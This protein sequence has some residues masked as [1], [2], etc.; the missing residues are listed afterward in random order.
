[1]SGPNGVFVDETGR[2]F[3]ADT[4]N[5]VIR[6]VNTDG[7]ITSI[8][9]IP[10]SS[11]YSGDNGPALSAELNFPRGVAV[12][13][14]GTVFI[15]DR[16]NQRIRKVT[17]GNI[18]TMAGI[19][20]AGYTGDGGLAVNARLNVPFGVFVDQTG[21]V[22]I[23][24]TNNFVERMVNTDGI[25]TTIAGSNFSSPHG[26]F[27]DPTGRLF[28]ADSG[29]NNIRM[30]DTNG[31]ST[32]IAGKSDTSAGYTGDG[33]PAVLAQLNSPYGVSVDQTGRVFIADRLNNA[34]R[35]INTDGII[36]TV[37]GTGSPGYTGDGGP[38]SSAQLNNPRGVSVD[39]TG[40]VFIADKENNVIR[41]FQI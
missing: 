22:F 20:S 2:V 41:V 6:M 32:R 4:N 9:G 17:Y 27:V 30:V 36:T 18:S 38:A 25:I 31:L 35:M 40:R 21:R 1:L 10:G 24:D 28:I 29:A 34:I 16:S 12:D 19:G 7:I 13:Q 3:I 5:Q 39:K 11:G 33:G 15:A 14:V 37:A 8:A 23:A 26:V